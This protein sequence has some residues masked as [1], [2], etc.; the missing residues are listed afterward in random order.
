LAVEPIGQA[1]GIPLVGLDHPFGAFL[2]MDAVNG[3]I[4]LQEILLKISVIMSCVLEDYVYSGSFL[5]GRTK[6]SSSEYT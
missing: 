5:S 1:K 2:P 4:Q 3:H 6:E